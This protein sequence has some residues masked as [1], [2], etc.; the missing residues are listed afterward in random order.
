MPP[1]PAAMPHAA[2]RVSARTGASGSSTSRA[3]DVAPSGMPLHSRGGDTSSPSHV[4]RSGSASPSANAG[5][6]MRMRPSGTVAGVGGGPRRRPA[7]AS[8]SA[9]SSSAVVLRRLRMNTRRPMSPAAPAAIAGLFGLPLSTA[10]T[11][12]RAFHLVTPLTALHVSH[13][14]SAFRLLNMLP[15]MPLLSSGRGYRLA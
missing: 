14:R 5:L 12:W 10:G 8:Y 13:P 15:A 9:V 11:V 7:A 4:N 1:L 2:H 3:S 6:V